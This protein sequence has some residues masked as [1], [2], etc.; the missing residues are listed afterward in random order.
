MAEKKVKFEAA[1][2]ELNDIAKKLESGEAELEEALELFK[3]G[4]KLTKTCNKIL[5]SAE[6]QIKIIE[7]ENEE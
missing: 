2:E 5:D 6:Q 3:K 4:V 7:S 1:L